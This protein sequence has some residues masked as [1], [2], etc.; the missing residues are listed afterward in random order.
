M[1]HPLR[2][3]Q[4]ALLA[5]RLIVGGLSFLNTWDV[6]IHL[7]IVVAAIALQQWRTDKRWHGGIITQSAQWAIGI[8]ILG[9]L[10]YL[11][12]YT[13]FSLTSR[14]T[15]HPADSVRPT[16]LIH[17][18]TFFGMPLL[19]VT[20]LMLTL[21]IQQR[22]ARWREGLTIAIALPVGLLLLMLF[23][24]IVIGA[25]DPNTLTHLANTLGRDIQPV[26]I[27]TGVSAESPGLSQTHSASSRQSSACG[28]S[29][30]F[31][32]SSSPSSSEQQ[33]Q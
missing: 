28:S 1:Q 24:G 29:T 23:M 20:A 4:A 10:L 8:G 15:V 30:A 32:S 16:R 9:Y 26:E 12:F 17:F 19:V 7:F 5:D 33:F 6:L 13:G 3:Q 22:F 11:P 27:G 14:R 21:L 2:R 18:L 31:S 25:G